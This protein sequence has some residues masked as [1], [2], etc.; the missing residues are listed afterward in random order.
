MALQIDVRVEAD[1]WKRSAKAQAIMRQAV[2]QAATAVSTTAAEVAI[3]LT[4]DSTIRELNREWRA[5][6]AATNVLAFPAKQPNGGPPLMGDIVLAY[7]TIAR[8]ARLERK[9]F[10]HHLAHLAVHGFLHLVGYDHVRDDDA[11]AME[12]LEQNILRR[13]G[14]PNPHRR[15]I[16]TAIRSATAT[17]A[18]GRARSRVMKP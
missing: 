12:R 4:D 18:A 9:P 1:G 6:D 11:E 16:G 13:I 5:T 3:V 17:G 7:Q 10:A 2:A 14:I 15:R 8:E